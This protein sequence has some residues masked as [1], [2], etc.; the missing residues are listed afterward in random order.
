MSVEKRVDIFIIEGKTLKAKKILKF[1]H[2]KIKLLV[3]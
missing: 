2:C 3:R 1:C